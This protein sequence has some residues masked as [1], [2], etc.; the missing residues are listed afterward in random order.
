MDLVHAYLKTKKTRPVNQALKP[1]AIIQSCNLEPFG[2]C[3]SEPLKKSKNSRLQIIL[4]ISNIKNF[5]KFTG[6]YLFWG[7][8][9]KFQACRPVTFF[10]SD[11]NI[12]ASCFHRCF[13]NF[14]RTTFFIENLRKLLLTVLSEYSEVSH[15]VSYLISRLHVLS[16]LI[17]NLRKTLHK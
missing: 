3:K 13:L 2:R 12:G 17:K 8:F 7:L 9:L 4:E 15:S 10:K 1:D 6:K 16:N 11:F 5:A 14:L